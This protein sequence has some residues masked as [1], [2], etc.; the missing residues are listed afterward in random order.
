MNKILPIVLMLFFQIGQGLSFNLVGTM[1]YGW[2]LAIGYTLCFIFSSKLFR[3]KE[4]RT[5]SKLYLCLFV[6]QIIAEYMA[7]NSLQNGMKGVA[8]DVVSYMSFFFLVSLLIKNPKL[9]VWAIIGTIIRMLI[10]G[11]ESDSSAEE[12]LRGEDTTYLKFYLGPLI[13]YCFLVIS[14][15]F[16]TKAFTYIYMFVGFVFVVA[17]ARS[18]GLITFLTG[19]FV[20]VVRFKKTNVTAMLKRY[21]LI[22]LFAFYGLYVLY[23]YNVMNGNISAGNNVQLLNSQNPYNPLEIIKYSRSDA[24]ITIEEIA[25]K[26][27]W[28]F[29]SWADD[30]GFKYH[31]MISK[32]TNSILNID[33]LGNSVVLPAHSVIFG[34][35]AYNGVFVAIITAVIIFYFIK[36]GFKLFNSDNRYMFIIMY[37]LY[38]LI[39]HSLFSPV[40]HLRDSFPLFFA[41][42]FTTWLYEKNKIKI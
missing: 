5:V 30:P 37:F 38:L 32:M 19:M 18:L 4:F 10:F 36:R 1:N 9:I 20:F 14:V 16:R 12:A 25:D 33:A 24:W 28:G 40:G 22:L 35:A 27:L 7:G 21:S 39:W 42:I 11:K 23:V 6:L 15:F 31:I 2:I 41:F 13:V 8:I 3:I 34:K 26:P 17:G 29:G